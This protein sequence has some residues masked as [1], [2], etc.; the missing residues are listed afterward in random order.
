MVQANG[1]LLKYW[2]KKVNTPLFVQSGEVRMILELIVLQ[3]V[4]SENEQHG[5]VNPGKA[6]TKPLE[7]YPAQ[8]LKVCNN[9]MITHTV[10]VKVSASWS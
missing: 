3:L 7:R 10:V 1:K 2:V 8:Q 4:L 9:P 5:L 6:G